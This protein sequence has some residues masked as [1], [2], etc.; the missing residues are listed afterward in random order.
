MNLS[1]YA[2]CEGLGLAQLVKA[3]KV[4]AVDLAELFIEA[5]HRVNLLIKSVVEVYD[6]ALNIAAAF[7]E[8]MPWKDRLTRLKGVLWRWV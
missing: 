3:G 2:Q 7:E 8:I 1:E 6:D 5:V 4:T